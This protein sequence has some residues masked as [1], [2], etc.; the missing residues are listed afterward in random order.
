MGTFI[1]V[2]A[3]LAISVF[4]FQQVWKLALKFFYYALLG[5]VG[6][7][8]KIVVAI[9]RLGKVMFILYKR[10]QDGKVYKVEFIDEVV[11]EEDIPEG[12]K[13]ELEY[14]EEVIVKKGDIDPTE[15]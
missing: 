3:I 5:V 9:R 4:F 2:T 6:I 14:H 13:N 11:E 12:L 8:R 1:I 15:F 7:V 10:H